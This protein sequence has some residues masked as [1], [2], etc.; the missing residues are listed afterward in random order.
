MIQRIG[1]QILSAVMLAAQTPTVPTATS[2][3]QASEL[4]RDR[5][6]LAVRTL[7]KAIARLSVCN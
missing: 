5:A 2:S 7:K 6:Q 1:L 4:A 3:V